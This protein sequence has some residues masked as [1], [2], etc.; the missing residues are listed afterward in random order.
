VALTT[1]RRCP[2][3]LAAVLSGLADQFVDAVLRLPGALRHQH[4]I[5]AGPAAR[6]P[7]QPLASRSSSCRVR[8]TCA[9]AASASG[10]TIAG[11]RDWV[12]AATAYV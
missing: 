6:Q 2:V 1:D 11:T 10:C 3:A 7:D 8:A 4:I 12:S 9:I 5:A